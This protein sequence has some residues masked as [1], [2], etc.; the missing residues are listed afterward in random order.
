MYL[1]GPLL[2]DLRVVSILYRSESLTN[3]VLPHSAIEALI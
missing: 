1:T 3:S 2:M